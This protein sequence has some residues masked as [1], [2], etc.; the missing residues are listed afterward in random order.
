[1]AALTPTK[2]A[3]SEFAGDIKLYIASFT[4]ASASDTITFVAAT[5]KFRTI[6]G[7]FPFLTAGIDSALL[8]ISATFSGLVVTVLTYDQAG[9]V[10]TDW[11]GATARLLLIVGSAD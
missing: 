10:A 1:M 5:H 9:G 7:A 3:L 2:V 6:Y 8:Q 11:T 4:P